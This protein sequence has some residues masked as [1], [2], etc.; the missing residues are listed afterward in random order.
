M[1]RWAIYT[2]L[3]YALALIFLTVPVLW[4]GLRQMVRRAGFVSGLLWWLHSS[5]ATG[6]G[7][8]CFSPDNLL[9]LLLPINIAERRL[10][11]RRPLKIPVIVTSFFL[12]NL[13]FCRNYFNYLPPLFGDKL[14]F[15]ILS[16][17]CPHPN[18]NSGVGALLTAIVTLLTFWLDLVNRLPQLLKIR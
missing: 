12:A 11:A 5:G 15:P 17:T 8:P 10:P 1:K 14:N 13:C 9:L 4:L 7:S 2:V 6:C 18:D 16:S 3:L